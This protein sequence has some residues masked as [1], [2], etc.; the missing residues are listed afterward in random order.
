M[1]IVASKERLAPVI[2]SI[3]ELFPQNGIVLLRGDLGSGKT[4]LVQA[5]VRALGIKE[6]ATSPT[7]L[8]QQ[9]YGSGIYHYDIYREGSDKFVQMGLLEELERPGY[10]FVEWADDAFEELLERFGFDYLRI[11]ITPR[12]EQREYRL[13]Y[14][15]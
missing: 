11:T 13:D 15:A 9:R 3:R 1:K 8:L 12:G 4:T 5:F 7:F 14:E 10:H 2:A 6:E